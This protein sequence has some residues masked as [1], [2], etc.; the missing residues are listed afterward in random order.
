MKIALPMKFAG[1]IDKIKDR[2]KIL[3][4]DF[5]GVVKDVLRLRRFTDSEIKQVIDGVPSQFCGDQRI[6]I[7]SKWTKEKFDSRKFIYE[8]AP[9]GGD[10]VVMVL[11]S[12][13]DKEFSVDPPAPVMGTTGR[14]IREHYERITKLPLDRDVFLVNA[15]RYQ[16]SLANAYGT[17]RRF[18]G[19]CGKTLPLKEIKEEIVCSCLTD[20]EAF[21]ADL[22][23][24][25][26]QIADIVGGK[27][28]LVNA[29]TSGGCRRYYNKVTN[30][31]EL[32]RNDHQEKIQKVFE[33]AHPSSWYRGPKVIKFKEVEKG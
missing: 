31:L 30:C 9:V 14:M 33:T 21:V 18:G 6:G 5:V 16:C 25:I 15:V 17:I 1:D 32:I 20:M 4:D 13:N 2:R 8:C 28:T 19:Y 27:I 3:Y 7:P 22:C 11:E 24:G 10:V 23:V 26:N 29:C 12:P